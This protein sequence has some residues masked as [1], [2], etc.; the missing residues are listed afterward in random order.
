[1]I[2][3]KGSYYNSNKVPTAENVLTGEKSFPL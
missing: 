1:M 3:K 2:E